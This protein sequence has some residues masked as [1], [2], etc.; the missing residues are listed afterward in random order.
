MGKTE[1]G[2]SKA[3]FTGPKAQTSV[4]SYLKKGVSGRCCTNW[5]E[6]L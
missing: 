5:I 1:F 6:Q 3:D 4:V 2:K